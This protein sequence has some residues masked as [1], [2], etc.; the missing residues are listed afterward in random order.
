M[1]RY[2]GVFFATL[3]LSG[4]SS[5]PTSEDGVA[6]L[7]VI[8]PANL[9]IEVGATLQITARALDADGE[10][11]DVVITW[12]TADTTVTVDETG[13][14]TGVS[15]G[16]GRIQARIDGNDRLIS[17]FIEVTVTEPEPPPEEPSPSRRR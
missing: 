8:P 1:T 16:K 2:A 6:V 17:G 4:C 15:A 9:T 5:L 11:V 14:V 3:L 12:R 10:P 7:E 13:L